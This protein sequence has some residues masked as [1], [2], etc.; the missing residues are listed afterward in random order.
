M[1]ACISFYL[2]I[3]MSH[4]LQ[5][6]D[7]LQSGKVFLLPFTAVSEFDGGC[8]KVSKFR[9][10]SDCRLGGG[11]ESGAAFHVGDGF[12]GRVASLFFHT[13]RTK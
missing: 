5:T 11:V 1:S 3:N 6:L 10:S 8:P 2:Y 4:N 13:P 9:D 7:R 12:R